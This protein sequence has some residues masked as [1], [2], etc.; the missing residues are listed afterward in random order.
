MIVQIFMILLNL[1]AL[2]SPAYAD[3]DH[4]TRFLAAYQRTVEHLLKI[5]SSAPF[6]PAGANRSL[7]NTAQAAQN[8]RE[9]P[10]RLEETAS[11]L[12]TAR[13]DYPPNSFAALLQAL[14]YDHTGSS[15]KANSYFVEFLDRSSKSD[16]FDQ[17]FIRN[18]DYHELRRGVLVLLES[19][20]QKYRSPN[21]F[22]F[23]LSLKAAYPL[24]L[25]L[26]VVWGALLSYDV[27]KMTWKRYGPL[28]KEYRYCPHC[29]EPVG[30]LM[31]ECPHCRG[32]L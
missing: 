29:R 16:T 8:L 22:R 21:K 13:S 23:Q 28:P 7:E 25:S 20:G 6:K 2:S 32:K 26:V 10:L 27:L 24:F 4:D 31:M 12:E 18:V 5:R 15:E 17:K 1:L 19:R 9:V 11:L 30:K 3:S 14:L